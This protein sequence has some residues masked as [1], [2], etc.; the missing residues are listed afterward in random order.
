MARVVSAREEEAR[1]FVVT[2]LLLERRAENKKKLGYAG[3][4]QVGWST[5][6]TRNR[7]DIHRFQILGTGNRLEPAGLGGSMFG[8]FLL[9]TSNPNRM[10]HI[11]LKP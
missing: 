2:P 3:P 7:T 11:F 5:L 9:L 4:V 10:D 6:G 1:A 8:L